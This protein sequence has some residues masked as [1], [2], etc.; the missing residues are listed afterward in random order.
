MLAHTRWILHNTLCV[1]PRLHKRE[2]QD[3]RLRTDRQRNAANA[4]AQQ[5]KKILQHATERQRTHLLE[6]LNERLNY[7]KQNISEEQQE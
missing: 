3:F 4:L 7:R 6:H 2:H 1:N 5:G